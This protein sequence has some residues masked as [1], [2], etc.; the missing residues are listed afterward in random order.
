MKIT[1]TTAAVWGA[2][3]AGAT[4][5]GLFPASAVAHPGHDAAWDHFHGP[6]ALL[7]LAL[8]AALVGAAALLARRG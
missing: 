2:A 5:G 7:W 1:R 6:E 4:A 8:A 3:V